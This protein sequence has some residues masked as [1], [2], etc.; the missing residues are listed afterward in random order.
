ML[1]SPESAP[2]AGG[3]A[4][5]SGHLPGRR[6]GSTNQLPAASIPSPGPPRIR[7]QRAGPVGFDALKLN[8]IATRRSPPPPRAI[9]S[10]IARWWSSWRRPGWPPLARRMRSACGRWVR[11]LAL[12]KDVVV[13]EHVQWH[14]G[15]TSCQRQ[16]RGGC[17]AHAAGAAGRAGGVHS[18]KLGLLRVALGMARWICS[19]HGKQ[20][21]RQQGGWL[22][23]FQGSCSQADCRGTRSAGLPSPQLASSPSRHPSC[24]PLPQSL[25]QLPVERQARQL[26]HFCRA[27]LKG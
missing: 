14:A 11:S 17:A 2:A 13:P 24:S 22:Q 19:A 16:W 25:E 15:L 3:Q 7:S 27:F 21:P 6:R 12:R 9:P 20:N 8:N 10:L 23:C 1:G 18:H 5:G 4:Q 26:Q